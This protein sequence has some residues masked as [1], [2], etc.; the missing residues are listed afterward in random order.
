MKKFAGQYRI[1]GD[2]EVAA[3]CARVADAVRA[4]FTHHDVERFH[5]DGH[6]MG[7]VP[8]L[9]PRK[10]GRRSGPE[11]CRHRLRLSAHLTN[12]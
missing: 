1:Q 12:P 5:L 2:W 7:G 10:G 4:V 6:S 8:S 9:L 11:V 3:L